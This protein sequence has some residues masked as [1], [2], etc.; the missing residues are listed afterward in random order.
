MNIRYFG[1]E[2]GRQ[3]RNVRNLAFTFAIPVVM[4]L[5]FGG[6]YGGEFD[7]T[8]GLPWIVVTTVQM[9]GYGAMMAALSQ[10]FTIVNE[11]SVGW[12]RQLRITPLSGTG[13]LVTKVAAALAVGLLSMLLTGAVAIIG[14]HA[15]L[16]VQ[17][18]VMAGLGLWVGIIPFALIAIL[19]GQFAKPEFAQPL[20]MVTFLGLS[21]LGG[22]WVPLQILPS[23]VGNVAQVVPSYWLNRLGQMGA[24]LSG[25]ALTPALVLAGWTIVLAVL[26]TWRY[27]RDAARA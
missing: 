26:I 16:S 22:L 12:N 18:W 25:N 13:Y 11:R 10:A 23:W 21:I 3:I 5:I 6:A 20:F 2:M 7:K 17:G 24:S 1:L 27:R 4:L 8:T 9:A 19:I 15:Q 14:L